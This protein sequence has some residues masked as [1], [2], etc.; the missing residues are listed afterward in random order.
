MKSNIEAFKECDKLI[1]Q[2]NESFKKMDDDL[3]ILCEQLKQFH[4]NYKT[5][6]DYFDETLTNF[7]EITPTNINLH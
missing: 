4:I 5:F 1:N 7:T 6:Q 2:C 3:H